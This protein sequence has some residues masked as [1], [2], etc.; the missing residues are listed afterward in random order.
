MESA[1]ATH[2]GVD[3]VDVDASAP[4]NKGLEPGPLGYISNPVIAVASNTVLA[5]PDGSRSRSRRTSR[6]QSTSSPP[7]RAR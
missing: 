5:I 7:E 2:S 6:H 3:V 4:G 1:A